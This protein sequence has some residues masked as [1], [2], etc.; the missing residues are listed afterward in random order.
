MVVDEQDPD[1]P[2]CRRSCSLRRV[3]SEDASRP[4]SRAPGCDGSTGT[5]RVGGPTAILAGMRIALLG[6]GLIGGSVARALRDPARR[7]RLERRGRSPR[8]RPTGR[9]AGASPSRTASSTRRRASPEAAIDGADLVDPGR[10]G[11]GLPRP[12]RRARRTVAPSPGTRRG[13]HRRRQHEGRHRP[14]RDGARAAVR[15]WPPDG[16]ARDERLRRRRSADL[17]VDRPWVVVPTTRYGTRSSGSR[18]SR[19]RAALAR[20]GSVPRPTTAAVAGDQPPAARR[21]RGA[22][23][24]RRRR[25]AARGPSRGLADGREP[26]GERL[27]GTR[28]GS[29]AATSRWAP[30][31]PRRTRP[32]IAAR[33]RDLSA[34]LDAWLVELERPDGPDAGGDRRAPANARANALEAMAAMSD[35]QVLVVPRDLVAGRRGL[36]RPPNR[37][38]RRRSWRVVAREGRFAP[39]AAME[40]DPRLQAGHPVPRPARRRPLLPHAPDAGRR[41][42]PA[43]R[44]LVDRRGRPPQPGRRR[45]ARRAAPRVARGA[46]GRLRAGLPAARPAQRRHDRGRAASTSAPSSWPTPRAGRSTIRET[47]Q[48]DRRRSRRRRRSRPSPTTSRRGAGSSSSSSRRRRSPAGSGLRRLMR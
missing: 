4:R 12:A 2:R 21:R 44:P 35:E 13:R 29:P 24:G 40:D 26:R 11:A 18:R 48:A 33:L 14:A 16:R 8:G 31:S 22:R 41:R 42:R 23:R 39:R 10:A 3:R 9:G 37:R 1:R 25:T 6:L 38:A 7:R 43:P 15:R 28:P 46:R 19:G 27:G 47:R 36:E 34:V 30:A 32:A 17:F 5:E 20:S 45:P